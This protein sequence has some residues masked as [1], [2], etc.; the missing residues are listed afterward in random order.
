MEIKDELIDHIAHLARL[1]F[2]GADKTAIKKDLGNIVD[3]MGQ[4]N[5]IDTKNVEPLIY[6][7]EEINVLRSD[8]PKQDISHEE[9]LKNAP[10][11]D[12]D[13]FRIPKVL[14][15]TID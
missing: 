12:S 5:A 9:I 4:L 3:F 10:K 6:M 13:Y 15:K 7:S 1:S 8:V 14:D 2:T 11:K